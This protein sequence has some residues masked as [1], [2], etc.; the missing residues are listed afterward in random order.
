VN[1][2]D[3]VRIELRP[4]GRT[5]EVER[6]APLRDVLFEYGVEFPCGGRGRCKR[7][8]VQ[9]I[10]GELSI[11]PDQ[12]AILPAHEL[13]TGWRL[14]CRSQAESDLVL[15]VVEWAAPVLVDHSVFAFRPRPGLGVAVDLGTTTLV[16][17]L[18]DLQT[19]EVMAVQT[20]LNPQAA[21]GSDVMSRIQFALEEGGRGK[22]SD[23]IRRSIG[24]LIARLTASA[25]LDRVELVSVVIVGN[26]T[27]HHL[28][29][30]IDPE[31]LSH[32]PFESRQDGL[33][34]LEAAELGWELRGKP[35]VCFLP[36]LGGFVGSDVL[37]GVLA[38]KMHESDALVALIDL[39][40]NGEIVLG[41][42]QRMLCA[43]TAAGPAFEAGGIRMGMQ[44]TTGA[45]SEVSIDGAG[46]CC[47][48]L[49]EGP[50]RGICG[51]GLVDAVAVGLDLGRIEPSGR[52]TNGGRELELMPPVSLMQLDIRQLQLAKGAI[53]A[54]VQILLERFG[55]R[56][57]DVDRVYL[58]GA[59]GNYVSRASARRIGMLDFA[60]DV[61]EPAG[62][63]ALLGAKL[64]LFG[65]EL[66]DDGFA[67]IRGCVEHLSLAT[68]RSFQ[69]VFVA[70]MAFPPAG[71]R[72]GA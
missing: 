67:G 28:F 4:L 16:A 30:G 24:E 36:C 55:A 11:T 47:R 60:D 20:A 56:S 15:Q 29:C 43:S 49:G 21:Y 52:L 19:G 64:A 51:S 54:G 1:R 38:T 70:E 44:A 12:E 50:A 65:Q 34:E 57:S 63:T 32:F 8:S 14:G 13:A 10:E 59:F 69:E 71:D 53:A 61:V 2:S 26:T 37:A 3:L 22:L 48:V 25:K 23:L 17:Q 72:G 31:P 7:C 41:N 45:I 68:D 40:T 33:Q 27:M 6:G 42:R 66:E 5:I 9:V 18:L 46:L 58:A 62:N 35:R 39:G